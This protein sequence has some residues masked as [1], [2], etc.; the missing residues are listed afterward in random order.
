MQL[1]SLGPWIPLK[2]GS[3]AGKKREVYLDRTVVA[4][5]FYQPSSG[6]LLQIRDTYKELE[7][8]IRH[9]IAEEEIDD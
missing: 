2:I 4:V 5:Q 8:Q 9:F 1:F 7:N 3:E 6:Y